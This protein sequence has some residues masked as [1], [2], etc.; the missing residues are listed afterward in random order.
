MTRPEL[1]DWL[2]LKLAA[3]E[4]ALSARLQAATAWKSGTDASWEQAAKISG[5]YLR[6]K[7]ITKSADRMKESAA[8]SRIAE[9]CRIDV[10][11][12]KATIAALEA[13]P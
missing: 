1:L 3:A 6:G 10:D 7:V 13:A 8:Q 4:A 9:K 2:R 12:F 5:A 11:A